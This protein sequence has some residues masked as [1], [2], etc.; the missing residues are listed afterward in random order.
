MLMA[1][2]FKTPPVTLM[3]SALK[4]IRFTVLHIKYTK[5]VNAPC[6]SCAEDCGAISRKEMLHDTE[7]VSTDDL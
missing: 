7:L 4:Q 3:Q 2:P 1:Q 5:I 6:T